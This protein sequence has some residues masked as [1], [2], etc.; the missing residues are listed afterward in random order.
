MLIQ[1]LLILERYKQP[2]ISRYFPKPENLF[3]SGQLVF[4]NFDRNKKINGD[5]CT[6]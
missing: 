2:G 6:D 3:L 1:M 4:R 5:F